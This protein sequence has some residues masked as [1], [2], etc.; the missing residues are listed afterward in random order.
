ACPWHAGPSTHWNSTWPNASPRSASKPR[1]WNP[2]PKRSCCRAPTAA[3][4][5]SMPCFN[6]PWK[7]PPSPSGAKSNPPM[8][9]PP[10]TPCRGSPVKPLS[11]ANP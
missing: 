9:R 5:R 7:T 10:S 6:A 11:T 8:S 3:H 2:P 1:P 4:A